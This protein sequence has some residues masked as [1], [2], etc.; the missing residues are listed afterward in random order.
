MSLLR[1]LFGA[2]LLGAAAAIAGHV[3]HRRQTQRTS[4]LPEP[5]AVADEVEEASLGPCRLPMP[6][7]GLQ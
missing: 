6:Q 3:L 1:R 4:T 2:A 7:D 5:P